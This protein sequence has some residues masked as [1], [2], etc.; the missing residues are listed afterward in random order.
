VQ[1]EQYSHPS[2]DPLLT[3]LGKFS[4]P[5]ADLVRAYPGISHAPTAAHWLDDWFV[6]ASSKT[7]P[8][9]NDVLTPAGSLSDE[10]AARLAD[11]G[12]QVASRLTL[13]S[14]RPHYF[15]GFRDLSQAIDLSGE[16]VV[17]EGRNSAGKT[18][19]AEALE[20]LF[21][22]QLQ[23][24]LDQEQGNP[25]ELADCIQSQLRPD[26]APTYVEAVFAGEDNSVITVRRD[27]IADYTEASTSRCVSSVTINGAAASAVDTQTFFV[28][29]FAG[30]P[31]LLMQHTLREF[32]H[33]G[34]TQRRVYFERLLN[35]NEITALIEKA[36]IG[37]ARLRDFPSPTGSRQLA[38]WTAALGRVTSPRIRKLLRAANGT[39]DGHV[40]TDAL[41]AYAQDRFPALVP[42]AVTFQQ[43]LT[44]VTDEQRRAREAQFPL[45]KQLS[46]TR[47]L[48]EVAREVLMASAL[49]ASYDDLCQR[50]LVLSHAREALAAISEAERRLA[51]PIAALVA[52][53]LLARDAP[54]Q[55]CPLCTSPEAL[56]AARL[57]HI[58]NS[59]P[60][61][62]SYTRSEQEMSA[63]IRAMR[64]R[65]VALS[66]LIAALVPAQPS[67][68]AWDEALA[69]ASEAVATPA[70]KARLELAR[71]YADL[72]PVR[73][74]LGSLLSWLDVDPFDTAATGDQMLRA[75]VLLET[76]G[77]TTANKGRE[78]VAGFQEL[79]A[80]INSSAS[81]TAWYAERESW[82]A[83]AGG[84]EELQGDLRWE[85]SKRAAQAHLSELRA[86]LMLIRQVVL[87]GRRQ[88]FSSEMRGVWDTLRRDK[89]SQFKDLHIPAPSGKGYPVAI[90][91]RAT[92]DDG[93]RSRD[94]DALKVFSE[95]QVH[96]LGIAAFLTRSKLVGH[97]VI[98]L[99]DPVQSMD[100]EHFKTFAESLTGALLDRGTQVIILTHNDLFARDLSWA[101]SRRDGYVSIEL[102]H[103]RR[104]GC[105]VS[106][107][108]RRVPARL[109]AAE[110]KAEEGDLSKA[111]F[112]I[113]IALERLYTLVM[114][115]AAPSFN[116]DSW[117]SATAEYM[118]EQGVGKIIEATIP[119]SGR[120]LK[121]ILDESAAGAHD[122][123]PRG[124][125]DVSDAC[126][127]I[128]ELLSP[129]RVGG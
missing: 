72:A 46:P 53:G 99:D 4:T 107:S 3:L 13:H 28:T 114:L 7:G 94:V 66:Q 111:W 121:R 31:P 126:K 57:S 75:I 30:V 37:D 23:R 84:L 128:R 48:D 20:W 55:T 44:I 67:A 16:L 18:S 10:L 90:Q 8:T 95:S 54:S 51:P 2:G 92:L 76:S 74:A 61:V 65:V 83:L 58:L 71:V 52:A 45:L 47:A 12:A 25:R 70:Q 59:G 77:E 50:A 112:L 113:R 80:A 40:L 91:V 34:P 125:T 56:K 115:G 97:S 93:T 63:A 127:Y 86:K 5:L 21:T 17:V 19:L 38:R 33:S 82:L 27:L 29:H 100:E 105:T 39:S 103:S 109:R 49:R 35:M 108:S 85:D 32:V 122:K 36:V 119:G 11:P 123:A 73:T 89:Y 1:S 117:R 116:P 41:V 96:V 124:L 81:D 64:E 110:K 68:S 129:L 118:W 6:D 106:E 104:K 79:E 88:S 60:V 69:A 98:V 9:P 22:G 120:H 78:Y 102:T 43:A 14:V 26:G 24:R 62:E 101:H 87:E 42:A 15:R